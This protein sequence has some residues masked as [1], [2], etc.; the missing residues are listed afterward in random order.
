MSYG[1]ETGW[2]KALDVPP[3]PVP[4]ST[5]VPHPLCQRWSTSQPKGQGLHTVPVPQG[6][7]WSSFSFT[8]LPGTSSPRLPSFPVPGMEGLHL[9][10]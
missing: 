5:S 3:M 1:L 2:Q 4:Q 7:F 8:P 6:N 9:F 10:L